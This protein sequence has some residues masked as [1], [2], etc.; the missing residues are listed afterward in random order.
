MS[1]EVAALGQNIAEV[2]LI[3]AAA[4]G[5]PVI[6]LLGVVYFGFQMTKDGL[7]VWGAYSVLLM[8]LGDSADGVIELGTAG[9]LY[10]VVA[11]VQRFFFDKELEAYLQDLDWTLLSLR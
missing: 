9:L 10:L 3:I 1:L 2:A 4:L 6:T 5:V 8:L 7:M 11:L